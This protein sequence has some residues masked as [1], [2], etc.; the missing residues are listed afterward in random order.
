[1]GGGQEEISRVIFETNPNRFVFLQLKV[2]LFI[3]Y[4][5]SNPFSNPKLALLYGYNFLFVSPD[6]IFRS[7]MKKFS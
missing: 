7:N 2:F 4:I 1:M 6:N 5:N 3:I